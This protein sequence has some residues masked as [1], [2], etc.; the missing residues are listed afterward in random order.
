MPRRAPT[1]APPERPTQNIRFIDSMPRPLI[2]LFL[3][4]ALSGVVLV[5]VVFAHPPK[6]KEI[7]LGQRRSP[8][9]GSFSHDVLLQRLVAVPT[10]L[11][12]Y[13]GPP[14]CDAAGVIIEGGVPARDRI[15]RVL[16]PLCEAERASTNPQFHL[17]MKALAT[18]RI[19]FALFSRTGNLSTADL[20]ARRI[21]LAIALSRE[22]VP[23]GPI[24]PLLVH[25]G[26]HL[27]QG[28]PFSAAQEYEARV[29]EYAACI[30]L[31]GFDAKHFPRD[32][33]DAR[34]IIRLG[35]AGAIALLVSAGYPR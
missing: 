5:V 3:V 35:R 23:A 10:P 18:A 27:S 22:N 25:E 9:A 28:L 12:S 6:P 30:V 16:R 13:A 4:L 31:P 19:R 17:A 20:G 21:L 34:D 2:A 26:Y 11:P 24:A 33:S 1:T 7:A 32:C 14:G 15:D 8:P 29:A